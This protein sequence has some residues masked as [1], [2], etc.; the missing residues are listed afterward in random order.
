MT[1][2]RTALNT[3]FDDFLDWARQE[4]GVALPPRPT[5]AVLALLALRGADRRAGVPEPTPELLRRVL[6]E[7]LPLVLHADADELAAV[8]GVLGALADRVR[9]AGRLNTKRRDRLLAA[10]AEL[11]P[12]FEQAMGR[13][14]NL[15]WPRWYASLLRADGVDTGDSGAVNAWLAAFDTAPHADRPAPPGPLHRADVTTATFAGRARLTEALL[16]AFAHDVEGHSGAGPLLPAS[17]VL[18]ADRPEDALA[19]ELESLAGE[20]SDRWTATGLNE[21]L[22]GPY[23]HLA[24]G[25]EAL[26]HAVLADR[27]LDEH[28]DYYGASDVPLPPPAA[29]PA[30]AEIEA[31]LHGA[32]LPASLAA[33]DEDVRELAEHCGFPGQGSAVWSAGTPAEQVELGAD[34]LAV[35]VERVAADADPGD[36]YALD[37]AHILY[38]LYERG[39]TPDSVARKAAGH[40]DWWYD[41]V[42]EDAPLAVP[43]TAPA[44]YT[45]PTPA[46][47]GELTGILEL[48]ESDRAELDGLARA[49]AA[50]VDRLAATGC[51]FRTGDVFGLTPLGSAV[52]RHTLSVGHVAVP[53]ARAVLGWDAASLVA[54]VEAW[55]PQI[56]ARVLADWAAARGGD[57]ATWSELLAA[58]PTAVPGRGLAGLVKR[59]DLAAVPVPP[60][61]AALTDPLV[62]GHARRVLLAR[63]EVAP[64]DQVPLNAEAMV[65]LDELGDASFTDIRED[66]GAER[67]QEDVGRGPRRALLDAFDSAAAAWP[68]GPAE[69]ISALAAA[70]PDRALPILD[71]L[72]TRHPDSSVTDPAAHVLKEARALADRRNPRRRTGRRAGRHR[73]VRR[74]EL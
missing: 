6:L 19:D 57:D 73:K 69:L 51:V 20:L 33:G 66:V 42:L 68:G 31:L 74:A 39:C 7:D 38:T 65:L 17:E 54:A 26:P 10:V 4:R 56:A 55:P 24:P 58:V 35:V 8:P 32:P 53:D 12:E 16:E 2:T 37:A 36:A 64:A 30:P 1:R 41:P 48:T 3:G 34:I 43:D 5:D 23:E 13:P 9:A 59:L 63:G 70:D 45:T 67:G 27:F 40:M 49:L 61:K 71:E 72:R 18:A 50:V 62:G 60:L 28:L 22:T 44:T 29:L 21:A 11:V 14:L 47:L 25:P 46:E 52:V 15:T